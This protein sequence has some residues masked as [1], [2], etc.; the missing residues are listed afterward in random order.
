MAIRTAARAASPR[1]LKPGRCRAARGASAQS[2]RPQWRR[3]GC[4]CSRA[5]PE[6]AQ[7]TG[8]LV[9]PLFLLGSQGRFT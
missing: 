2:P 6:G 3:E 7:R 5:G 1:Y 4:E 8:T 9:S